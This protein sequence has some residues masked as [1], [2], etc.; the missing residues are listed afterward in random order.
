MAGPGDEIAA[1]SQGRGHL[2]A[3]RADRE[4]VVGVLKTAFVQ[5][6]I[7]KH[8]FDQRIGE[9]FA[10]RTYAELAAVTADIPGG[11]APAQPLT[12][13]QRHSSDKKAITVW[14][15]TAAAVLAAASSGHAG[16]A[17]FIVVLFVP[18][19]AALLALLLAFHAWLDRRADRRSARGLPPG[20][21][22]RRYAIG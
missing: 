17:E 4:Y 18:V 12:V 6:M 11:V 21:R 20:S 19:V 3:S 5:G 8:E 7:T 10:S 16:R 9:V 22:G 2:R 1:N 13:P 15:C 14:A